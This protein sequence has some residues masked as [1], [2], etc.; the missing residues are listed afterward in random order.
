MK[1]LD[2]IL[3]KINYLWIIAIFTYIFVGS[4]SLLYGKMTLV[5]YADLFYKFNAATLVLCV[6]NYLFKRKFCLVDIFIFG[7][8]VVA[9]LSTHFSE[10][11]NISLWGHDTRCEGM[12]MFL[13]YYLLFILS[14]FVQ[15]K[16][17]KKVI[18]VILFFGILQ[19]GIGLLQQFKIIPGAA[20]MYVRG[21]VGNSN[22]YSTQNIMWLS[23]SLGLFIFGKKWYY[24]ILVFIFTVGLSLGGAMSCI[25]GLV[26]VLLGILA[27]LLYR[28]KEFVIKE[29]LKRYFFSILFMGVI[30]LIVSSLIDSSLIKDIKEML[31]QSSDM[32]VHHNVQENYGTNRI[33]IWK[34]TIPKIK[35][36]FWLGI[37]IDCFR[38]I[39]TP[40]LISDH[41]IVSKAHNEYLQLLITEGIG[42]LVFYLLLLFGCIRDNV[43][44]MRTDNYGVLDYAI[45]LC[46][47][48]YITQ[49]FFNISVI[50][51]APIF[52]VILGLCHQ[53]KNLNSD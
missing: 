23:L 39:F 1:K 16:D 24:L 33:F 26:C 30:F 12:V 29:Y 7:L 9:C 22:F 21:L 19:V 31:F 34:N 53:R 14:T 32:I 42:C 20:Y 45:L 28:R 51:V 13:D 15:R 35:D 47:I 44:R 50:R 25:V 52:Y 46:V 3:N 41:A 43:K 8:I 4:L 5:Q 10:F 38:Y 11:K 27:I 18:A 36:Y 49:A 6:L 40:L 2:K 48:G 37:G 17:K